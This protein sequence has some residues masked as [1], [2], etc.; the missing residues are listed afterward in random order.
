L[1]SIQQKIAA[2]SLIVS[3]PMSSIVML[4][5]YSKTPHITYHFDTMFLFL[6]QVYLNAISLSFPFFIETVFELLLD[7]SKTFRC[8]VLALNVR[9]A[10]R[11][12]AHQLL[13]LIFWDFDVIKAKFVPPSY[14]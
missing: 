13:M 10:L 3:F 7:I 8:S 1:E 9:S 6:T 11:L 14:L 2:I 4:K 5:T 12:L